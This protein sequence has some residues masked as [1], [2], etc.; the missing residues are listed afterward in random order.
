M[1]LGPL[2]LVRKPFRV[3]DIVEVLNAVIKVR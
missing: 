1:S 2:F 3:G